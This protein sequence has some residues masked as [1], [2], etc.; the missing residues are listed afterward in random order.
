L[1]EPGSFYFLTVAIQ[2]GPVF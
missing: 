2:P 1:H